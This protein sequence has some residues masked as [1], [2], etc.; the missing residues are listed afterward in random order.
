MIWGDLFDD[1]TLDFTLDTAPGGRKVK[2]RSI[3]RRIRTERGLML[4][5]EAHGEW[6]RNNASDESQHVIVSESGCS[7]TVAAGD[8]SEDLAVSYSSRSFSIQ[9]SDGSSL[10]TRDP[11]VRKISSVCQELH[12]FHSR[13]VSNLLMDLH[14]ASQKSQKANDRVLE[15]DDEQ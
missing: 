1:V 8:D 12:K 11:L 7:F 4:L 2:G 13:R 6:Q 9:A 10:E 5:W 14:I 15:M 3:L